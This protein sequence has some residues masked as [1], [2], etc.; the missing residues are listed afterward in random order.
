MKRVLI[1]ELKQE[2]STFN[3]EPTRYDGFQVHFGD[4]ILSTF[5]GTQT[6]LAGAFDVFDAAGGIELVPTMAAASVSGG[7][8]QTAGLERLLS[9]LTR[10][11]QENKEVDGAYVCFHGAMAGEQEVDPEGR[12]LKEIRKIL[13]GIPIVV[14]L[15]LHA[16]ITDELVEA[17]DVLVPFHT[18]PHVDE[19]ETGQRS[20]RNLLRLLEGSVRP[21]TARVKLPM[22]V[23]GD[24]LI[25]ATGR[26]GDAIRMCREIEDSESGLAA[27]VIIGNAFTDVPALQSN[28]L[29]TTDNDP[30]FAQCEAERIA[31][32][33]WDNRELFQAQ[34]TSLK[35]A[36]RLAN[37]TDGLTVFSD[38][39]DATASGASGD[40][41][42]ILRGLLGEEFQ[43]TAL[44]P[45]V[46]APAVGAALAAGV[47]SKIEIEL[48]GTLDPGRFTPFKVTVYVKS[49]HDGRFFYENGTTGFGGRA[50]VL[51]TGNIDVL[52]TQRAVY[53]VGRK[54]FLAHGLDPEDYD[55]VVV[56]SPNGF[57]T[58]YESIA[59]CIV[60]VDV[61]GSTSA[62]LKSLPYK[63]CVRPIFPLDD[64]VVGPFDG[65]D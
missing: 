16:V 14:S 8:I 44:V 62:N 21:T 30:E 12:V 56:K 2:T 7:P 40:S 41:N 34:L 24:E 5:R 64:D 17:A 32:F 18:Y 57:R 48:G 37:D 46:D 13:G 55:V 31:R 54:V 19:Y 42:E 39:A 38:A 36:I 27:G 26:F 59:A 35:E 22:L 33:M 61:P 51:K 4:E 15:D 53:V 63:N 45:I 3:P 25:T 60:P 20:A 9:E 47:G 29:V 10:S 49:L 65:D 1:A 50:V 43:G 23:R 52:V 28:V 6:E 58:Y 11:V